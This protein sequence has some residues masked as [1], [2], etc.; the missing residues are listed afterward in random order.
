MAVRFG[1]G[2]VRVPAWA[3][4]VV[5]FVLVVGL[6]FGVRDLASPGGGARSGGGDTVSGGS[7][8]DG[9]G[10]GTTS[11]SDGSGGSDPTGGEWQTGGS[12]GNGDG[13]GGGNGN[14]NSDRNGSGGKGGSGNGGGDGGGNGGRA[15]DPPGWLPWGPKSPNTDTLPEPDSVYDDLQRGECQEPYEIAVDPAKQTGGQ[16]SPGAWKV[17]EGLAGI[18]K[19]A[20]GERDGLSIATK[21]A[22]RLRAT[23]YRPE[24]A[25]HLCKDGDALEVLQRFVAYY[26]QHP[27][28]RVALRPAPSGTRA[29]EN[30]LDVRGGSVAPDE[31]FSVRGTWPD[32][33][34]T[35]ELRAAELTR[36]VVLKP[37]GDEDDPSRCCKDAFVSVD[38]PGRD[39][40]DGRRPTVVDVTLVTRNGARLVKYAALTIVWTGVGPSS[41]PQPSGPGTSPSGRTTSSGSSP[42]PSTSSSGPN[43]T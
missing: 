13:D 14:G 18:C 3:F 11:G 20:R 26:R 41:P 8:A 10:T 30:E 25:A 12:D 27:S 4:A 9:G 22:A 39:G 16:G 33:P 36:P 17:I 42:G 31:S 37:I 29:C 24:S 2:A 19:A 5:G 28:E 21:A 43:T 7:G 35:V 6:F 34:V 1:S 15:G 32:P 38:L 23:G 40:F